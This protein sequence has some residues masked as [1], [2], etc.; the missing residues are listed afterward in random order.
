VVLSECGAACVRVGQR[1]NYGPGADIGVR[2]LVVELIRSRLP[3]RG[4]ITWSQA[5]ARQMGG[6]EQTLSFGGR[7]H[8][9]GC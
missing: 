9:A 6:T 7:I 2:L 1:R 3:G 8:R 5:T 4:L